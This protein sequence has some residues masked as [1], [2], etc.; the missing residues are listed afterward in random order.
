MPADVAAF[1]IRG[2]GSFYCLACALNHPSFRELE[3]L[4]AGER[5]WALLG[6]VVLTPIVLHGITASP[7]M[8]ALGR[9]EA[10]TGP[11]ES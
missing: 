4:I 6:F 2:I 5:P 11:A 7:V 8:D 1:G 9:W 10:R 3:L